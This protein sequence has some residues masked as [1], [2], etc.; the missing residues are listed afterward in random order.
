MMSQHVLQKDI[1]DLHRILITKYYQL[2][3]LIHIKYAS[4]TIKN[5]EKSG[6]V[7]FPHPHRMYLIN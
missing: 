2:S 6:F 4:L 3:E 5:Q 1:N 7:F